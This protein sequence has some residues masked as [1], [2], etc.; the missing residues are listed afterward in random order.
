MDDHARIYEEWHRYAKNR[1]TE[2]L[3]SLYAEDGALCQFVNG[4]A[5]RWYR[6]GEYLT[7]GKTLVWEYPRETPEGEQ[8][9]I[10]EL[11]EISDGLIVNHRIYWGWKG[12]QHIS[13]A[14]VRNK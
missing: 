4:I 9:D 6:T 5:V 13:E 14:L 7:N 8:I 10:L 1:D 3:L 12:C 2:G 11:M